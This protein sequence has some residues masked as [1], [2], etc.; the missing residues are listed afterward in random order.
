MDGFILTWRLT[1]LPSGNEG[2]KVRK[3]KLLDRLKVLELIGKHIDVSA[4]R[5]HLSHSLSAHG[6]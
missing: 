4:F 6:S 1:R 2:R 5:E 3:L